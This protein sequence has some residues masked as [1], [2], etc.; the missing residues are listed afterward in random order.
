MNPNASVPTAGMM[1]EGSLVISNSQ[2]DNT[3]SQDRVYLQRPQDALQAMNDAT[4]YQAG[5][6][7]ESNTT[8]NVGMVPVKSTFKHST[9][10]GY[11]GDLVGN[12]LGSK[13]SMEYQG[14]QESVLDNAYH[15]VKNPTVTRD[16]FLSLLATKNRIVLTP[17]SFTFGELCVLDPN[18]VNV[19]HVE[20]TSVLGFEGEHWAG[21]DMATQVATI[22]GQS[23]PA[24][25]N[26]FGFSRMQF[27]MMTGTD[28]LLSDFASM[29][30]HQD[31][32]NMFQG[33]KFVIEKELMPTLVGGFMFFEA[34][35][36]CD[37]FGITTIHLRLD[38]VGMFIPYS[39]PSFCDSLVA[40]VIS[41]N[42]S[43]VEY[44]YQSVDTVLSSVS[45]LGNLY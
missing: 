4:H 11:L 37:L 19:M 38:G 1:K 3:P 6:S 43:G 44:L 5:L 13:H 8:K 30:G 9:A 40:P 42:P 27:N 28:V 32:T 12:Y 25:L 16:S 26:R 35:V 29:T 45:G 36:N 7:F 21:S 2:F 31:M 14:A 10:S 23:V 24:Y 34:M 15:S 17:N 20:S 33:F 39:F 18:A 22:I 41:R